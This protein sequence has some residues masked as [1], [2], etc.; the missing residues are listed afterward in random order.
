MFKPVLNSFYKILTR[1]MFCWRFLAVRLLQKNQNALKMCVTRNHDQTGK[2]N[3]LIGKNLVD[4][5]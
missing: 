3:L 1:L 4:D 5:S 2:I